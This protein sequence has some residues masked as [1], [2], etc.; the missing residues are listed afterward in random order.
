MTHEEEA[1]RQQGMTRSV[2]PQ[3][4]QAGTLPLPT[5]TMGISA[6]GGMTPYSNPLPTGRGGGR[7]KN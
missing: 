3:P 1:F 2:T 4:N 7:A 6:A 5:H